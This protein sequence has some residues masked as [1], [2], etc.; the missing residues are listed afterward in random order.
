MFCLKSGRSFAKSLGARVMFHV[1]SSFGYSD[2]ALKMIVRPDFPSYGY[3]VNKGFNSLWERIAPEPYDSVN[4][5][6]WGDITSWFVKA[7][8]GLDYNPNAGDLAHVD[9]KP[10]I[11]STLNDA[12]ACYD[13]NLGKI[14]SSWIR[15]SDCV[16]LTV[17][18]PNG[19]HGVIAPQ[20]GYTFADG[21]KEKPLSNG[22]YTLIKTK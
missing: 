13:S 1:L 8:A 9:I 10:H 16:K 12:A 19:M 22:E 21:T 3:I 6:F 2:L 11:V 17:N 20:N 18:V 4:H 5:H 15:K 14:E 7:L